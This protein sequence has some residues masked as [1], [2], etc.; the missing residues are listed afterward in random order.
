[1]K[2]LAVTARP[3]VR[4]VL[5]L[6]A[7]ALSFSAGRF[8]G[9]VEVEERTVYVTT[10]KRRESEQKARAQVV[11]RYIERAPTDAGVVERISERIETRDESKRDATTETAVKLDTSTKTAKLPDWR[12]GVQLGATWKE[13]ALRLGDTPLVIGVTAERRIIGGVSAGVWG[14]T[15]GAAGVGVSVEF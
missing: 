1:M 7:V 3:W 9:P 2:L 5:V 8:S 14:S 4:V 13:P 11:T 12:V 6:V 15:Q 10:E